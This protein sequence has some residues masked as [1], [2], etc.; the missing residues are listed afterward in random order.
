MQF[1]VGSYIKYLNWRWDD[2]SHKSYILSGKGGRKRSEDYIKYV[3][4][5]LKIPL[6]YRKQLLEYLK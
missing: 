5:N 4:N 2:E 6:N 3:L 1:F